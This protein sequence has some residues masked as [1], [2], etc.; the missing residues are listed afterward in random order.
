MKSYE[1]DAL[2]GDPKRRQPTFH[3]NAKAKKPGEKYTKVPNP[4]VADS[5]SRS[6]DNTGDVNCVT[7]TKG[8]HKNK[9]YL[10]PVAP[11]IL[12]RA[13]NLSGVE[14]SSLGFLRLPGSLTVVFGVTGVLG[15]GRFR[16]L[17]CKMLADARS[18]GVCVCVCVF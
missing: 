10:T 17:L 3:S 13:M 7:E 5:C 12:Y 2:A 9:A 16:L 15:L 11:R 18:G 1:I 8:T 14:T 4:P 6:H